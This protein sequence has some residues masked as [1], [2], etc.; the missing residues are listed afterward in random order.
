[1]GFNISIDCKV[2]TTIDL[3]AMAMPG[4]CSIVDCISHNVHF[5]LRLTCF[6]TGNSLSIAPVYFI[7]PH[8]P[9]PSQSH[10]FD[11]CICECVPVPVLFICSF[12]KFFRSTIRTIFV[13]LC[14]THFTWL[15]SLVPSMLSEMVRFHS[16]H[17]W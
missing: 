1:M 9:L 6:V 8:N 10:L 16:F 17:G 11:L 5:T 2:I 3:V 15:I 13:C 14:K 12:V 7:H 4:Y